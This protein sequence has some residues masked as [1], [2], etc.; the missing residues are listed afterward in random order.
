MVAQTASSRG[1]RPLRV[2]AKIRESDTITSF[3]LNPVD[4][5]DWRHFEPGQFL[6]FKI[7][8]QSDGQSVLRNYSVSCAPG[9]VGHYRISVKREAASQPGVPDG[10]ASC[11]LHDHVQVGDVL[12]AEGPRGE[13]VLDRASNR[14]VVLLSGGVGLTPLVSMLHALARQSERRVVFVHAC[15]NGSVHALGDEVRELAASRNGITSHFVY[16]FPTAAD[17]ATARHHDEGVITRAL[18]QRLLH[19]D[20]YDFYLCGPP[21]F[22]QAVYALVRS[23]GV[24][25]KRIAYEFFGPATVLEQ[26]LATQPQATAPAVSTAAA[27]DAGIQIHFRKS[28][29]TA[30]WSSDARSLLE[31]AESVGLTPDFSCRAGVCGTCCTGLLDGQINYF[32]EPLDEPPAHHVL[33]CC[34][35]PSGSLVLDL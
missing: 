14:P 4:E 19:L 6:V 27:C 2:S 34:A 11:Y 21:P 8:G 7:P 1:F 24:A 22:M 32:E 10:L 25:R 12:M 28:G 29:R 20:D 23:L 3:H 15:D 5:G 30:P 35:R 33:L 26:D 9:Q 31:F 13:F 16:R 18:L 17:S